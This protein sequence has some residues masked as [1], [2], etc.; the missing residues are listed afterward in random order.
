MIDLQRGGDV[1]T[2]ALDWLSDL[3]KI[4]VWCDMLDVDPA[5]FRQLVLQRQGRARP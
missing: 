5:R 1:R 3:T 4:R 2:E